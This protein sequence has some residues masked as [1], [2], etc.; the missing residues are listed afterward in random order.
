MLQT[1][2]GSDGNHP[3]AYFQVIGA[4]QFRHR[5]ILLGIYL[6]QGDIGYRVKSD[7][8]GVVLGFVLKYDCNFIGAFYNVI[9]GDD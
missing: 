8:F 4:S 2:R 7:D 6:Y 1:E 9:V 3:F 5:Q